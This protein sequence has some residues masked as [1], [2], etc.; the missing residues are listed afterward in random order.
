M[1]DT[2]E[3]LKTLLNDTLHLDG[4]SAGWT[5]ETPLL[6]A[7]PQLDS[8]AVVQ[9]VSEVERVFGFHFDDEDINAELFSTLGALAAIV[10]SKRTGS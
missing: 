10:D 1:T 6:G 2:L 7:V 8:M 5:A 3:K 4:A 9:V